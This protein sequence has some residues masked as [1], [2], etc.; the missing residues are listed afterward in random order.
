MPRP[1]SKLSIPANKKL[2][3][4]LALAVIVRERRAALGLSQESLVD[5]DLT[6]SHLSMIENGQREIGIKRFVALA[7]RLEVEPWDLLK[8]VLKRMEGKK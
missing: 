3:F 5:T 1:S 4:E 2:S 8:E 6:Q 7:K